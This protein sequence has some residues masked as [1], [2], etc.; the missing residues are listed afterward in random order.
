[1]LTELQSHPGLPRSRLFDSVK[2]K[3][4][5]TDDGFSE[6]T[7]D[8]D[9]PSAAACAVEGA[10]ADGSLGLSGARGM[11]GGTIPRSRIWRMAS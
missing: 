1:M 3:V 6:I 7:A 4:L 5:S 9:A 10:Y 2:A 8:P 11:G